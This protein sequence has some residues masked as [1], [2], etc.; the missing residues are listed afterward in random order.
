MGTSKWFRIG[1]FLL[2][3]SAKGVCASEWVN[4]ASPILPIEDAMSLAIVNSPD[5][6]SLENQFESVSAKKRA[7]LAPSE[8][9]FNITFNDIIQPY[10]FST[11]ASEVF[12]FTQ[13]FGFPGKAFLNRAVLSDQSEAIYAQLNA[14]KLQVSYNVKQAYYGLSLAQK[15]IGINADQKAAF[16]QILAVAK[17]RYEGGQT[18]QVD[19]INSQVALISNENDLIDL[20]AA[21]KVARAQLNVL[22]KRSPDAPLSVA[23]IRMIDHPMIQEDE[24]IS[25]MLQNRPEIKAAQFQARASHKSYQLAWMSL[26]PDFQLMIGTTF[27]LIPAA[28]PFSGWPTYPTHTY[29]A[30]IQFTVPLW[31]LFN[32]REA[33]VAASHDRAAAESNLNGVFNQSK[34]ALENAIAQVNSL[35]AKLDNYEKHLLPLSDQSFNLALQNYGTGKI[36]FQT[37]A[38]TAFARKGIRREYYTAVV[39]YLMNYATYG[40]LIGED[41]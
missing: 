17:R 29:T 32:E 3:L 4:T 35:R 22:L 6:Q 11:A 39:N 20:H 1:L 30:S 19:Y 26:L 40:Q 10:D 15:N 28:S 5:V 33:I 37:L 12:Q 23:P 2:G 27:Y 34:T 41:L 16:K 9:Y 31:F 21:E 13:P 18:S 14:S 36:D 38:S 7:A 24:A 25:K 8:P